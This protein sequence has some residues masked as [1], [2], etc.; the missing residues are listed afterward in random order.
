VPSA[1][2]RYFAGK[3]Y[4]GYANQSQVSLFQWGD[5]S[6][7]TVDPDGVRLWSIQAY[8][9][10]RIADSGDRNAWG[11]RIIGITP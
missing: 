9:E 3:S 6:A 8:A 2:V 10:D 11:T 1:P 7:T 5:Y 4:F